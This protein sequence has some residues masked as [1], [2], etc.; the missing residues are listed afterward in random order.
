VA[1]CEKSLTSHSHQWATRVIKSMDVVSREWQNSQ[2]W[3]LR[4]SWENILPN[5]LELCEWW[6]SSAVT[7]LSTKLLCVKLMGIVLW[8]LWWVT[9]HSYHLGINQDTCSNEHGVCP[10]PL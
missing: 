5:Y 10:M 6:F 7:L 2:K 9:H 4:L 8:S 3:N 1:E